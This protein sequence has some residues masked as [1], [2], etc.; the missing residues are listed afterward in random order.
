MMHVND[1][2][3][4]KDFHESKILVYRWTCISNIINHRLMAV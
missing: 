1:L 2:C 3:I 4:T